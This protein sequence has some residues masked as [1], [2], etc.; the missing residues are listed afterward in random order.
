MLPQSPRRGAH[1]GGC[2]CSIASSPLHF[3]SQPRLPWRRAGDVEKFYAGKTISFITSTGVAGPYDTTARAMSRHMHRHIPGNPAMVVKNMPGGGHVLAT[4][5]MYNTAPRDGTHIATVNGTIP[6]HQVIDGTGVRFDAR[7]FNWLG[8]TASPNLITVTWTNSKTRSIHDAMKN[9]V[10]A[11]ATGAGSM[12]ALYP[13][14]L[15]NVLG[16]KFKIV[17]GYKSAASIDL[18]MEAGE[19]ESRSGNSY[20]SLR[21]DHP[22]WLREGKVNIL[23]QVGAKRAREMPD[24]PLMHELART[25][26]ERAILVLLSSAVTVGRPVFLPPETPADRV[27]A[28]RKAF[29]ATMQ[30]PAFLEETKKLGLEI[31]PTGW[32][33]LTRAVNETIDQPPEVIA[34]A[35][36]AIQ[37]AP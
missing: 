18:A 13:T 22:D 31:E 16:T 27:A 6:T 9:E 8:S 28:L 3:S 2:P 19:V 10:V 21:S 33:E 11:G 1:P 32:Q 24:V 12:A 4:N 5:F 14:I 29:D 20:D 17:M 30:D 25:P 26:Q 36:A 35:R 37:T 23:V 34:R 15:N 7:H